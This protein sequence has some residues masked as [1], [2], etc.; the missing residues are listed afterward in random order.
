MSIGLYPR[1]AISAQI[2]IT[3]VSLA[4]P[5]AQPD[6]S[7][8]IVEKYAKVELLVTLSDVA[9]TKFYD[10]DPAQGGLDLSANFTESSG[11]V[12]PVKGFYDGKDWRIRFSPM[13]EGL[14]TFTVSAQDSSGN[15]NWS[16]GAFA[17]IPS[18]YPGFV[19]IDGNSL[20]FTEGNS[21]FGVGHNN[22]WQT[23]VEQ[24][25]FASM[26]AR[27]ENL[28]SFWLCEPWIKGTDPTPR[29]PIENVDQGIGVYNQ[30]TCAY[31]DGVVARAESAGVYLL[32]SIWP[33]DSLCDATVGPPGRQSSW[34]NNAYSSVCAAAEFYDTGSSSADTA[35]WRYQKNYYRYLLARWG[36]SR[37]IAGWVSVVETDLTTGFYLHSTH[38]SP[39]CVAV[40]DF[41]S[42]QDKYRTSSTNKY[43]IA[44]TKLEDSSFDP[45]PM[46]M[47]ATDSYSDQGS[48][49]AIA[50]TLARETA[51]MRVNAK[52]A[53][54]AEF[55]GD[56]KQGAS[57]PGHLHNGIWAGVASG[58]AMTPLLWCDNGDFPML[59]DAT[60]GNSMRNQLQYLA[61][62]IRGIDFMGVATLAPAT[63]SVDSSSFNALGMSMPDRGFAWIQNK[64][65]TLG[66]QTLTVSNLANGAYTIAWFDVWSSGATPIRTDAAAA[67]A[68]K[69]SVTIPMLAQPD[70]VCKFI[71][72]T[73]PPI[74]I[75]PPDGGGAPTAQLEIESLRVIV[76]SERGS[77][78]VAGSLNLPGAVQWNATS[79]NV[80]L[81]GL[82]RSFAMNSHARGVSDH[83]RLFMKLE[84]KDPRKL[85]FVVS[86]WKAG[87]TPVSGVSVLARLSVQFN[88]L[89]YEG[90]V[91][92]KARQHARTTTLIFRK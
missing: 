62:F 54:H 26:A 80:T 69:L 61:E 32:P 90:T 18:V 55:G 23:D 7:P 42:S 65:G 30:N 3:A 19:R 68:G 28:L 41:F 37:A 4:V 25:S 38:V 76:D 5:T 50:G 84:S 45:F 44:I 53:F 66:A 51:A 31:I 15:A 21:F 43:P 89:T 91:T 13:R 17:C 74:D 88:G 67:K 34:A 73:A 71:L 56:V 24:P 20:R 1:L 82:S 6:G 11:T 16:L 14:W 46:G 63:L 35:Q 49:A 59:T 10:P 39:W 87:F 78:Y 52:P 85:R 29:A 60:V 75:T 8:A 57:Q 79:V 77:A 40:Q 64:A 36:Y 72:D 83:G 81:M 22:G 27:G 86:L 12:W 2:G 9:A 33:H 92:A 58:A 47:R 70:I 48:N